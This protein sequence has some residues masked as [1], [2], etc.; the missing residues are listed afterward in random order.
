MDRDM[1][2][3]IY[4]AANKEKSNYNLVGEYIMFTVLFFQL[5]GIFENFHDEAFWVGMMDTNYNRSQSIRN[6][7]GKYNKR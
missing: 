2:R 3:W 5:F 1:N 6:P 7:E 4:N